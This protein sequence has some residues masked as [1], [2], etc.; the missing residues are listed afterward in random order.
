MTTDTAID[1]KARKAWRTPSC[2][3]LDLSATAGGPP[4]GVDSHTSNGATGCSPQDCS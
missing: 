3:T 4:G 2:Q 1:Q